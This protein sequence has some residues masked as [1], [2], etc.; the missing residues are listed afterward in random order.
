MRF[1][2]KTGER[3]GQQSICAMN[4]DHATRGIACKF[5]TASN[6]RSHVADVNPAN[7]VHLQRSGTLQQRRINVQ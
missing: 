1:V 5:R 3:R 4:I 6:K 7:A 2:L